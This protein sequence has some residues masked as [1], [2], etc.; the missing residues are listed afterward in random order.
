MKEGA[1]IRPLEID[2][3]IMLPSPLSDPVASAACQELVL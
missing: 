1:L 3:M 2:A